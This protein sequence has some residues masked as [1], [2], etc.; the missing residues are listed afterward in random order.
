ME[1]LARW[2]MTLLRWTLGLCAL[3]LVL[4]ALY[5][6]LGRELLPLAAEYRLEV[7]DKAAA[8]LAMPVRIGTLEGRWQGFAPVLI[9][10]D[11]QVGEG[12][13][14]LQLDQVRVVPDVLASLAA[15]QLRVARLELE[16]LQLLVEQGAEGGWAL[17][18]LAPRETAAPL[19]M[20]QLLRQLQSV[21]RLSLLNSQVTLQAFEQ[22]ARTLT[23]VNLTLR[24]GIPIGYGDLILVG[25]SNACRPAARSGCPG[26][27]GR[28]SVPSAACTRRSCR[29]A[30]V[31]V[32]RW[33]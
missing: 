28:Y 20:A 23:Y 16:G 1:A 14:A 21:K 9:A 27:R 31:P 30:M 25:G 11:L 26:P 15:R 22:P 3:G 17:K 33:R 4:A 32:S 6:S 29:G 10:H 8:A 13:G 19:D 18:G 12:P 24:N 2:T 5:V 7:E